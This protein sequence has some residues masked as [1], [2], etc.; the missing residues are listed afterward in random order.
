MRYVITIVTNDGEAIIN[1]IGNV[2]PPTSKMLD[3]TWA[4]Y[5]KTLRKW[6]EQ[7]ATELG[8]VNDEQENLTF[9]VYKLE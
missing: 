2:H 7:Y 8:K 6:L 1:I 3:R 4:E 5:Q 9:V